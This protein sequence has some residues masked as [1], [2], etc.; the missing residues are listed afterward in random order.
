MVDVVDSMGAAVKVEHT[1]YTGS[2]I[3]GRV[4]LNPG[5]VCR[6][7]AGNIGIAKDKVTA[8]KFKDVTHRKLIAPPGKYKFKIKHYFSPSSLKDGKGN[9][10]SPNEDDWTG[11]VTSGWLPIE[12]AEPREHSGPVVADKNFHFANA[13]QYF[14][15]CQRNNAGKRMTHSTCFTWVF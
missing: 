14:K 4:T 1:F 15:H 13:T 10:I 8:E 7:D 9:L 2:I 3:S 12:I 5:Q 6:F 11:T